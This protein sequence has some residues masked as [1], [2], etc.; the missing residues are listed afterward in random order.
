MLIFSVDPVSGERRVE[1]EIDRVDFPRR[2]FSVHAI[3]VNPDWAAM[4]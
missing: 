1:V 3:A 2:E 4:R